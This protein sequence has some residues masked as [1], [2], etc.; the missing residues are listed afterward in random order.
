MAGM[1]TADDLAALAAD[2]EGWHV[3]R[4]RSPSGAEAEWHATCRRREGGRPARL[5]APDAAGLREQLAAH[6]AVEGAA[7]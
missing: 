3:W 7:A 5:T 2:F 6:E 4:G 1:S